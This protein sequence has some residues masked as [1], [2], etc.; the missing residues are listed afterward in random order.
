MKLKALT[1]LMAAGMAS[2]AFGQSYLRIPLKTSPNIR[3]ADALETDWAGVLAPARCSF[4]FG[5]PPF[6]GQ[7]FQSPF[8]RD[9][10]AKIINAPNGPCE[11]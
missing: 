4:V 1:M 3:H 5:N 11:L 9:Q 8:Q 6:I 10:M 7:S 2:A